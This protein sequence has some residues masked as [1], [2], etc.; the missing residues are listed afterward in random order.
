MAKKNR[1]NKAK[2]KW[3]KELIILLVLLVAMVTSTIV[4]SI[5]S[6]KTKTTTSFN[7]AIT[8]YN[9]SN[10]TSYSTLSTENVFVEVEHKKLLNK[11]E[12]EEYVYVVYG[13]LSDGTVLQYLSTINSVATQE[14]IETVYFYSSAWVEETEDTDT[15]AFKTK[16]QELEADIN[17]NVNRDVEALD[18]LEYPALLVFHNGELIFNSQT[19]SD[20]EQYTWNMFI[21]KA[22]YISK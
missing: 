7:E 17:K 16:K 14:E 3:T 8:A 12:K 2:F 19:Y 4:L 20:N 6:S 15:E 18:L 9:T 21:Q 10:S 11:I 5:P 13:S 1:K 22:F